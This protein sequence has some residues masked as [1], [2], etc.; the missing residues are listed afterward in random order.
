MGSFQKELKA[1]VPSRF[2]ER[3][4]ATIQRIENHPEIQRLKQKYPDRTADLTSPRHY[5]DV[6]QHLSYC[7]ACD[8]CPGLKAC[9]NE[10]KG[11]MSVE[12]P[13]PTQLDEL[14]FRFRKCD[15]LKQYEKQQGIGQ[16]I[17]SH[18]IPS[19]IL[20][21]TFDDIEPDPQRLAAITA[22]VKFCS[23]FVPGET[24]E[25]L[26]LY[27]PM[28]VGKSKIAGAI[29][30]ELAKCDIDVL[31]VYVPDFL[32]E[33]K[34]AIGSKTETVENKLDSLRTASVLILDDIG[35]ETLTVWTRDEVI[36]PILQ[37]RMERLPIIY[38][39]NLTVNELRHHLA[40]VKDAKEMD[41]KQHEKKAERIIERIEPFVKILPVGGRNRRRR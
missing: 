10:Q 37:R 5:R 22:A 17:K 29:A 12:E 27:G 18:Y 1:L 16:R 38:T 25:G 23:T 8:A 30:Q 13:S 39:S 26:Y 33:V 40:N 35:A 9:Q 32:L 41:R 28:G 21:A 31:M 20:D 36:G 3:Q 14:V 24:T 6:S 2:Y 34:D 19:H 15:L 4:A 11:H 7:D